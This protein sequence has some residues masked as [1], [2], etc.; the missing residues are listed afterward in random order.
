MERLLYFFRI[1]KI[2][3]VINKA[4]NSERKTPTDKV[5]ANPLIGPEPK[6]NKNRAVIRVVTWE[7]IIVRSARS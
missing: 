5:T 7:S 6:M 3:L 1:S 4:V 2:T